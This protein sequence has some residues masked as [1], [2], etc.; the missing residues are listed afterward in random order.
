MSSIFLPLGL[1]YLAYI[2]DLYAT[3]KGVKDDAS[4]EA[5]PLARYLIVRSAPKARMA[6]NVAYP[7]I[8]TII[9][10]YL[11]ILYGLWLAYTAFLGHLG[12]FLSWTRFNKLNDKVSNK[13]TA[14]LGALLFAALLAYF[15]A[16]IHLMLS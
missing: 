4:N 5:N 10:L 3:R 8:V 13:T 12:G 7:I 6:V 15:I 2:L 11:P 1:F 14:F 9:A 16:R